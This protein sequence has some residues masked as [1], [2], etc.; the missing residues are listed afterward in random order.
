[1]DVRGPRKDD[2][3]HV[4]LGHFTKDIWRVSPSLAITQDYDQDYTNDRYD[5]A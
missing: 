1:M 2:H 3:Q 4:P 5:T